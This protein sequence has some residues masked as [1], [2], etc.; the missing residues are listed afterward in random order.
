MALSEST[1]ISRS[2]LGDAPLID[3][4]IWDE[5]ARDEFTNPGSCSGV[6]FIVK[7]HCL[8]M[9]FICYGCHA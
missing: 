9:G 4:S 8:P 5:S 1:Q 2:D 6:E 7:V 3:N